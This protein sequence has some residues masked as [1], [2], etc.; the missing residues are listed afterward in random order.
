MP[1]SISCGLSSLPFSVCLRTVVFFARS[2]VTVQTA[3]LHSV[4]LCFSPVITRDQTA[5][6]AAQHA[7]KACFATWPS[8]AAFR[9][10]HC[11]V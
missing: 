10:L 4:H 3:S 6:L 7:V 2:S 5:A 1:M 11:R 9:G 8:Y